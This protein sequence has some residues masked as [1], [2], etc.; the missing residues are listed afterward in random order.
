MNA[1]QAG[2]VVVNPAKETRKSVE[3]SEEHAGR[4]QADWFLLD[5]MRLEEAGSRS[6][7]SRDCR[8]SRDAIVLVMAIQSHLNSY[9]HIFTK[10]LAGWR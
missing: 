2:S 10:A 3:A 8:V 7:W 1:W 9:I 5:A 6:Q 4:L